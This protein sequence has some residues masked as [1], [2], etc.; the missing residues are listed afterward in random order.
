MKMVLR[1]VLLAALIAAGVWLWTIL[2]PGPE[3]IIR[4]RLAQAAGE[5]SFRSGENPLISAARAENL[6]SRFGTNV[7]ININ[8]PE[9][10]RQEFVR[11]S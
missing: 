11:T 6:A 8:V 9:Y 10:G 1:L 3:K 2:F 5:A 7:E 4:K